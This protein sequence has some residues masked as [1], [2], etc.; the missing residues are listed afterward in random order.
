MVYSSD[1]SNMH[2]FFVIFSGLDLKIYTKEVCPVYNMHNIIIVIDQTIK[3]HRKSKPMFSTLY[4]C[5]LVCLQIVRVGCF[6]ENII[7]KM[8]VFKLC[9]SP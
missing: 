4:C 9:K 5:T 3:Y 1:G 7:Y 6:Q 2:V 8:I